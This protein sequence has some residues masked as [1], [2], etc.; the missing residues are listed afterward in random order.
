MKK[1]VLITKSAT[2]CY[3]VNYYNQRASKESEKIDPHSKL[4]PLVRLIELLVLP[5]NVEKYTEVEMKGYI[6][7]A[8]VTR[9]FLISLI[10]VHN[11]LV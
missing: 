2:I 4:Y 10:T 9:K 3:N 11:K 6:E 8:L 1:K 7:N 5:A